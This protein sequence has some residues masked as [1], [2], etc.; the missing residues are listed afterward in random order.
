MTS[1]VLIFTLAAI[2]IND[3]LYLIRKRIASQT[4]SL[5]KECQTV[6]ASKYRRILVIP[7]EVLGLIFY[8]IISVIAAFLVIG[9]EPI[10]WWQIIVKILIS[11]GTLFS[12]YFIYLQWRVIKVWCFWCLI[13]AITIFLM[14][15]I[16][17][18]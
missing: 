16:I 5:C 15:L 3:T 10:I 17:L 14:L 18:I 7:N 1:Y 8:V 2:G 6:L 11:I 9:L 4:P 13:S 12:L